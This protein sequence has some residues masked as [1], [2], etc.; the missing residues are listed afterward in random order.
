[1]EHPHRGRGIGLALLSAAGFSTL[2]LFARLI[3]GE[4]FAVPAALAWRF[5]MASFFLWI[6]VIATKRALP[7]P[8]LPVFLLGLVGFS[9]Q[10]GLYFALV[11]IL[12]PGIASLLLYLYP[13][14]V[15]LLGLLAFR[16]KPGWIRLLALALSLAGCLV[17]FWKAGAYPLEGVLLGV[18][19]ALAYA[20]YLLAGERILAEVDSISATTIVMS[21]AALVYWTISLAGGVARVPESPKAWFGVVG[22]ALFATVLPITT[23]FASMR[24]IGAADAS[25]VSTL[26]PVLTIVLSSLIIGERF[27]PA[28]LAGGALILAAVL[29]IDLAPRLSGLVNKRS[30]TEAQRHRGGEGEK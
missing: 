7:K 6:F 12:D 18:L 23:L 15:V 3:Y 5:T 29:A 26:E 13:S 1:V 10:A 16:R 25:L 11:R 4:G 22:V 30:A 14:F 8:I 9:P 28:Q 20:A 17:T 24:V 27:G 21:A 19:V 2:G